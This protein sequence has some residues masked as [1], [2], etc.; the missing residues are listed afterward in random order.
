MVSSVSTER[1]SLNWL[2]R[3]FDTPASVQ[4]MEAHGLAR[5]LY[6]VVTL[7]MPH[8]LSLIRTFLLSTPAP[9]ASVNQVRKSLSVVT[10]RLAPMQLSL[11]HI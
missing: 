5:C 11:I 8:R 10:G 7:M 2:L 9:S 6:L 3:A 1:A 4:E